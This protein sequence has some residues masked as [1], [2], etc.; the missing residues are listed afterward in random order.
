MGHQQ[1]SARKLH[2]GILL[3][4]ISPMVPLSRC[5]L[6]STCSHNMCNHCPLVVKAFFILLFHQYGF[7]GRWLN[8]GKQTV[9]ALDLGGAS[10]QITFI[11][12]EKMEDLDN[13]MTLRLYGRDY[14]LYTHSYLCY[15]TNEVLRRLLAHLLKVL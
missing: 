2:Q 14:S 7:I 5:V 9:G 11:N 6:F 4:E 8:P 13:S 10:T 3:F 12:Q 1:L 15:G